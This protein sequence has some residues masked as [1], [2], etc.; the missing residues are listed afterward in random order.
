MSIF[1]ALFAFLVLGVIGVYMLHAAKGVAYFVF[2][3]AIGY[4]IFRFTETYIAE[5]P[6]DL[7]QEA[8]NF[9]NMWSKQTKEEL[10]TASKE[11][12]HS[13]IATKVGNDL[14]DMSGK[15]FEELTHAAPP[16]ANAITNAVLDHAGTELLKHVDFFQSVKNIGVKTM[17]GM[18][19]IMNKF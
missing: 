10:D 9:K 11:S 6:I 3:L 7:Q 8:M 19:S 15:S 1:I 18:I 14:R 13:G 12:E 5:R 16:D 4:G 17:S 2:L